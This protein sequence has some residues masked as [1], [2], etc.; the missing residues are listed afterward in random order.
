[1]IIADTVLYQP[2]IIGHKELYQNEAVD[3]KSAA[4]DCI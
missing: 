2:Q 1:M 4:S 3:K